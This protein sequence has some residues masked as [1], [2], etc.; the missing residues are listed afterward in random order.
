MAEIN[1]TYRAGAEAGELLVQRCPR[2]E[3]LRF[4][5]SGVCPRCLDA[6]DVWVQ[7]SGR[8]AIWSW[9][10][11]HKQYFKDAR[12]ATP[13][14]VVMVQLDEGPFMI[15]AMADESARPFVGQRV[16]AAFGASVAG[17]VPW[18]HP[19]EAPDGNADAC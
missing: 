6:N 13:Y 19:A 4:P 12:R 2:C 5:P 14:N 11:M 16:T 10:R 1:Q 3:L 17:V 7:V 8:G 18:F 15:S 9:I